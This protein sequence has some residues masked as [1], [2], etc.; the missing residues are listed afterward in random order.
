MQQ[1]GTWLIPTPARGSRC[2][3]HLGCLPRFPAATEKVDAAFRQNL[4]GP[5]SRKRAARKPSGN[6]GEARLTSLDSPLRKRLPDGL[7][8]A[9]PVPGSVAAWAPEPNQGCA[10][11]VLAASRA[12]VG[13]QATGGAAAACA[14]P[15]SSNCLF[16][17]L[18]NQG[19]TRA[20]LSQ[21]AE[22]H[23]RRMVRHS[24]RPWTAC[25]HLGVPQTTRTAAGWSGRLGEDRLG[26]HLPLCAHGLE[27]CP[28]GAAKGGWGQRPWEASGRVK[29]TVRV[30]VRVR[31]AQASWNCCKQK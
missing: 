1:P 23:L 19:I 3:V 7:W 13:V 29:S 22:S 12:S 15:Q 30:R 11:R 17:L 27:A 20:Q 5:H 9:I 18:T 21:T 6:I 14:L 10:E 31:A 2:F 28:Q 25:G 24:H 16:L 4:W 26:Q 8:A